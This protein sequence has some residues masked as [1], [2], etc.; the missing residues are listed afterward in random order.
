[1]ARPCKQRLVCDVA[2]PRAFK[3]VGRSAGEL[4]QVTMGRDE[5]EALRLADVVG[6]YHEAAADQMGISRPTFGRL[7][8]SARA[9][10]AQAFLTGQM[11][12]V[13]GGAV[14]RGRATTFVCGGCGQRRHADRGRRTR[15]CGQCG[16]S[17]ERLAR[18]PQRRCRRTKSASKSA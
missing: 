11:I 3:P 4:H 16:H 2:T 6:L 1:M 12:V 10:L 13:E 18:S 15:A 17:M 8:Q 14:R 7:I 9:K 5:V